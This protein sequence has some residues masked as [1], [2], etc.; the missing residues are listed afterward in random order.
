[1]KIYGNVLS[2]REKRPA[3]K[4][5]ANKPLA[6]KGML[7]LSE[8][9][10]E[11]RHGGN[12][13]QKPDPHAWLDFSANINPLG[14]PPDM[15]RALQSAHEDIGLYPDPYAGHATESVARFLGIEPR[16]LLLTNG[17]ID[18]LRI[19]AAHFHIGNCVIP[20]PSFCE[21]K[22]FAANSGANVDYANATV[23]E[24]EYAVDLDHVRKLVRPRSLVFLCNPANPSGS[25]IK[26]ENMLDFL[27][28]TKKTGAYTVI[29]EA[30][31]D[32]CPEFSVRKD[33]LESENTI[34]AGS[35][36]KFFAIPGLRLGYLCANPKTI[37]DMK[38]TVPPWGLN[39]FALAAA[40]T[41]DKTE[42][43]AQKTRDHVKKNRLFLSLQLS[44]LGYLVYVSH[45]NYLLADATALRLTGAE[46]NR[47]L[48]AHRIMVRDCSGYEGLTDSHVR[49][50][51]KSRKDNEQ[52]ISALK[53]VIG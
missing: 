25:A 9:T 44:L 39:A 13:W 42:A 51:V 47:R 21:Y 27:S 28:F 12:V 43:Y 37:C 34:I 36:T 32:F 33:I 30:F 40:R 1:M 7:Y 14:M 52:L 46:L 49:I 23:N 8:H 35:L 38:K 24:G 50:A 16:N 22:R 15:E 31:V 10:S 2:I 45:A 48:A 3:A 26:R 18:A 41:L 5:G 29:D 6:T 20:V 11:Y 17:G 4:R 53:S 19:A